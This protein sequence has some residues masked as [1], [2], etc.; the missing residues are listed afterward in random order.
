MALTDKRERPLPAFPSATVDG[1]IDVNNIDLTN[2]RELRNLL[3]AHGMRPNKGFGQNFLVDRTILQA[4]VQAADISA[5]D[6]ILE[7]G[8]GTG[9]L[10]RELAKQARRVVAVEL[11]RD[12]L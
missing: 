6:E 2:I 5:D 10:T 4:I 12:M 9:V 8:A 11:E 3:F 1:D 7:V